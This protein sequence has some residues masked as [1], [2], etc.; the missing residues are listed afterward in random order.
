MKTNRS[1]I[2]VVFAAGI[3]LLVGAS[4]GL[5]QAVPPLRNT[6]HHVWAV[7][8]A[9][10][11]AALVIALVQF[12]VKRL[13]IIRKA[14]AA[15]EAQLERIYIQ[16]EKIGT[17]PPVCAILGRTNGEATESSICSIPVPSFVEPWGG[18]IITGDSETDVTFGI[19]DVGTQQ[20]VL[21]GK[22][23]RVIPV[24]RKKTK[25]GKQQNQ[26]ACSKHL[27]NNHELVSALSDVCPRYP[28]E[29][30]SY[31][32]S[33]GTESFEDGEQVRIGGSPQWVQE[34]EFPNCPICKK[35]MGLILQLPGSLLPSK[36]L[37]EGT[38]YFFGCREHIAETTTVGQFA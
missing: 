31:L 1:W 16:L 35:R 10:P 13:H 37:P 11:V 36:P 22:L 3:A 38:F 25:T 23:Y 7:L 5:S 18:R 4:I 21:Q 24:P 17:E 2:K 28:K 14:R 19:T 15:T 33:P 12:N 8:I 26:F 9:I 32:L 20:T 27:T 34:A 30:L 29:L 6:I